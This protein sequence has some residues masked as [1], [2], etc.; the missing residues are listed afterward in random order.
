MHEGSITVR[1]PVALREVERLNRIIRGFG[2]L[3]DVPS[4]TLY[5]IN[6]AIDE[7]VT[8]V[9]LHGFK[10]PT[11]QEIT[12]RIETEDDGLRATLIDA[13]REFDPRAVAPP[14]LNLPLEERALGGLGV[15]LVR[16]LMDRLDYSRHE[17][18]NVLTIRKRI[19]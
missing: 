10:D 7:L 15:H 5:A 1:L 6:L 19:R 9:I 14:N 16:S 4:R 18:K 3:H 11:N 17:G 12:V 13:G 2:E 8:N